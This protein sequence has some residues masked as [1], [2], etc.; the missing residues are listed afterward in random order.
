MVVANTRY[1]AVTKHPSS[2]FM[3][4]I[5]LPN[6]SVMSFDANDLSAIRLGDDT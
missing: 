4:P 5:R 1:V 2:G 3:R 6:G